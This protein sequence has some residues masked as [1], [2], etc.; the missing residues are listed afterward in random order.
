MTSCWRL[1][2]CFK[3]SCFSLGILLLSSCH[4][5][6][7]DRSNCPCTLYISLEGLPGPAD[8]QLVSDAGTVRASAIRDTVLA[9]QVPRG[10]VKL[11]ASAGASFGAD[12]DLVISPGFDCPPVHLYSAWVNTDFEET[13]IDIHLRK[14]YCTLSLEMDSPP[15]LGE[16]FWT[17]VRGVVGGMDWDGTPL[18]G[19]F[20]CRL[21]EGIPVRLPRQYPGSE[22]WLDI[23]TPGGIMRSFALGN[24]M[25]SAGYNWLETNLD[26][27][28]L[29]M[30]TSVTEILLSS[31]LWTESISLEMDI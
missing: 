10:Q 22:L 8:V 15:G 11:L 7:E 23:V 27:L 2:M 6:K 9:L 1:S 3:Y 24:Y 30:H 14:H 29:T 25:E 13:R 18:P 21:E 20:S 28:T 26:D 17:R 19:E 4:M 16:P 5:I 12:E 31:N